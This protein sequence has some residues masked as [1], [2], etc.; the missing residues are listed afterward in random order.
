MS[1]CVPASLSM[2]AGGAWFTW[3]A[4]LLPRLLA[5]DS[6]VPM[7]PEEASWMVALIEFG[8][9]MSSYPA[10]Y[11]ADRWGRKVAILSSAPITLLGFCLC[12]Y[13][14]TFLSLCAART[15]LGF[16][17]AIPYTVLP[18]YLGEI[19]S[20]EARG[21][22]TS[23]FHIAWGL[24]CLFPYCV[25]PF[26]SYDD[27][28]YLTMSLTVLFVIFFAWQPDTPFYYAFK[29]RPEDAA[30][31]L[32]RLRDSS[33]KDSI[34]EE[35]DEIKQEVD[36]AMEE[37]ATW[38]D[39]ISTPEDRYALLL[40]IIVGIVS[41]FSG[42]NAI[43]TYTTDTFTKVS[44]DFI[45][46]DYVTI[47]VGLVALL[48]STFAIFGSDMFGRRFLLMF[49]SIGCMFSLFAASA[50]FYLH[51]NT[52]VDLSSF[53]WVAPISV[54]AYNLFVTAGMHP[55]CVTYTSELFTTKTRGA[56]A[57]IS[58]FNLTFCSFVVLKCYETLSSAVGMYF[59]YLVF[60]LT[61]LIGTVLFYFMM[62][63]TKGK[64][65]LEIRETISAKVS[66]KKRPSVP[67]LNVE[68]GL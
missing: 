37:K 7:T 1:T 23:F 45:P 22:V 48:G 6:P 16:G 57:T 61:C 34:Q 53:Q 36:K 42:Q 60:G 44:N 54:M 20:P 41:F 31:A 28:S 40:I 30:K 15:I 4:P 11:I 21:T 3:P 17:M 50:Y 26:L 18:L 49:S 12:V 56:A 14:K 25:G 62:P 46:S 64:T 52:K 24:G 38:K 63:E 51:E 32:L 33:T 8:S 55:V 10:T 65:F 2:V 35:L 19:A 9:L 59:P 66:K 13:I 29:S 58:N 5:P 47:G 67:L 39:I 68:Q 43:L 27:F